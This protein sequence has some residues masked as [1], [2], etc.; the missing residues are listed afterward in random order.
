MSGIK[1]CIAF[2]CV[3]C[4]A[5]CGYHLRSVQYWPSML[6]QLDLVGSNIP[7]TVTASISRFLNT[8]NVHETPKATM[9]LKLSN[10]SYQQVSSGETNSTIPVSVSF[11]MSV[12]A[13]VMN[14]NQKLCAPPISLSSSLS[15]TLPSG[16]IVSNTSNPDIRQRLTDTLIQQL[17]LRITAKELRASILTS[18]CQL[19]KSLLRHQHE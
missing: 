13:T 9:I 18:G 16:T 6:H 14:R 5:G 12:N 17:Y 2:L 1:I 4:M 8:M 7:N 3:I 19:P 11:N 10:F 15:V